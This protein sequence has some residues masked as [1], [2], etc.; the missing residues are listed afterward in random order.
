MRLFIQTKRIFSLIEAKNESV[1]EYHVAEIQHE[2]FE[3]FITAVRM[4]CRK[5]KGEINE[6][7]I[8]ICD[9]WPPLNR[10]EKS[11]GGRKGPEGLLIKIASN[12][13]SM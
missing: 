11:A 3:S 12:A 9:Y 10:L 4:E 8:S 5:G 13:F 1:N 2:I 7:E 6:K